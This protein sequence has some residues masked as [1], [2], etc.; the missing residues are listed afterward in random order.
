MHY[1][2]L[3]ATRET[4]DS[5]KAEAHFLLAEIALG[6]DNA[7]ASTHLDAIDLILFAFKC[8][9]TPYLPIDSFSVL[10]ARV[11]IHAT[12]YFLSLSIK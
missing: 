11:S 12:Q 3:S 10:V 7:L 2:K 5:Y 4:L 1:K 9:A 6:Q 8:Y